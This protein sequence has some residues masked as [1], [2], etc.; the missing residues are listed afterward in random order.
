M[1]RSR[2]FTVLEALKFDGHISIRRNGFYGLQYIGGGKSEDLTKRYGGYIVVKSTVINN[3]L[4]I[5]VD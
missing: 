1:K 5:Y 4:V 2:L 3:V